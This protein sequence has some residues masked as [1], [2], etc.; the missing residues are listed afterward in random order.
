ML[1]SLQL[2]SCLPAGISI[3]TQSLGAIKRGFPHQTSYN[4]AVLCILHTAEGAEIG[5][6]EQVQGANT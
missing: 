6:P 3:L 5:S 1:F 2:L 4:T